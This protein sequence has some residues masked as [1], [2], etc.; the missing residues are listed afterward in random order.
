MKPEL[1]AG[2]NYRDAQSR[3]LCGLVVIVAL[4]L[5]SHQLEGGLPISLRIEMK[6]KV[7]YCLRALVFCFE[8]LIFNVL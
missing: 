4:W 3:P 7:D 2:R 8:I 1:P 6:T 5:N